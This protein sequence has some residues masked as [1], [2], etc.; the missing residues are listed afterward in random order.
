M[1]YYIR[2]LQTDKA[3]T[4]LSE[5]ERALKKMDSAYS[6]DIH[7]DGWYADFVHG[8]TRY[9]E[10]E[11]NTPGQELFAGE[12]AELKD[13]LQSLKAASRDVWK[14]WPSKWNRVEKVLHA[15]NAMICVRVLWGG[16]GMETALLKLDPLWD[17][18]LN[19]R[20]GLLLYDAEGYYD[21]T[22]LFLATSD[23]RKEAE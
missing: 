7:P 4:S 1:G 15:T 11:I 9:G 6:I 8:S 16:H 21:R 20:Q 22:G 13:E 3:K 12:M 23:Q 17:W 5:L 18:L 14:Q 10:I 2:F 19:H